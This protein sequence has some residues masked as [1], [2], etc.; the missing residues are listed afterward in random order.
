MGKTTVMK[1]RQDSGL[2]VIEY[3]EKVGICPV[4]LMNIESGVQPIRAEE[5]IRIADYHRISI[6]S[7]IE[8]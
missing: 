5:L 4:R 1:L 7:S 2:G 8:T 6:E 3:S